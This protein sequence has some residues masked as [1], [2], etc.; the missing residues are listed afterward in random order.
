MFDLR[1]HCSRRLASTN[2]MA[3]NIAAG[4]Q[5][6]CW[7]SNWEFPTDPLTHTVVKHRIW[8]KLLK[9]PTDPQWH[10]FSSKASHPNSF[11]TGPLTEDQ[12]FEYMSPWGPLLLKQPHFHILIPCKG[13]YLCS[14]LFISVKIMP[15]GNNLRGSWCFFISHFPRASIRLLCHLAFKHEPRQWLRTEY[16][17]E[18]RYSH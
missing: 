4:R 3:G 11:H 17:E 10:I 15:E 5:A 13:E 14:Q 16:L 6:W 8:H 7:H 12:A 9:L 18:E 2:N 1:A